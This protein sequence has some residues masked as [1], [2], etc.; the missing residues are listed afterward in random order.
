MFQDSNLWACLAAMATHAKDLTT[1][2]EAYAAI[3]ETDKVAYIQRIKVT[4]NVE[5]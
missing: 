4:L 2:E 5:N 3:S 1:A